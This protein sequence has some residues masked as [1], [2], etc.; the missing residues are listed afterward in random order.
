M[1][2]HENIK[3]QIKD[4][5]RSKDTVRLDTL[6]GLNALFMNEMVSSGTNTEYIADDKALVLIKRSIKQR[7]DSIDQFTKG[8]REDLVIKEKAELAILEAYMPAMMT[9]EEIHLIA[10]A[11]IE[12]MRTEGMQI[13]IKSS[14]K[15]VGIIMKELNGKADGTDVKMVVEEILKV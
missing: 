14:G 15:I 11:R 2:I 4:A 9:K 7:K 1:S 12:A 5:L 10:R 6:R 8:G 3:S 13:D